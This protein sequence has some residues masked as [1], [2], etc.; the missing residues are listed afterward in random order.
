MNKFS[1]DQY[2]REKAESVTPQAR[3]QVGYHVMFPWL[4]PIILAYFTR[5]LGVGPAWHARIIVFVS[6]VCG[7]GA[8]YAIFKVTYYGMRADKERENR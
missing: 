8:M 5:F 7:C 4:V 2:L 6:I 1:Y 3:I